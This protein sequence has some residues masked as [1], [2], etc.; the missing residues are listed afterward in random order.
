[1]SI[2]I[3]SHLLGNFSGQKIA[4]SAIGYDGDSKKIA[5]KLIRTVSGAE[6]IAIREGLVQSLIDSPFCVKCFDYGI[7][8][9]L[10]Y[11]VQEFVEGGVSLD[12]L[13]QQHGPLR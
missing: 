4:G 2:L 5:V 8:D 12:Q 9:G 3:T 1:M 11:V 6:P 10:V 7:S 13:L